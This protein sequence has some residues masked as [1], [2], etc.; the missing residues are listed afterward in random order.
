LGCILRRTGNETKKRGG[1]LAIL[2]ISGTNNDLD[3]IVLSEDESV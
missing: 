1:A 2:R 3:I